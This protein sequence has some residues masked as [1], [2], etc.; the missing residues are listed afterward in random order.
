MAAILAVA[1]AGPGV[2]GPIVYP[3]GYPT[4]VL[5]K[6]ASAVYPG[7]AYV[8][9]LPFAGYPYRPFVP[10]VYPAPGVVY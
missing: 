10:G 1:A 2:P 8:N 7:P 3:H 9:T 4:P 5:Y 6:G